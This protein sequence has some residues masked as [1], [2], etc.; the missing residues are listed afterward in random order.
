M[1]KHEDRPESA[2]PVGEAA[3]PGAPSAAAPAAPAAPAAEP[4]LDT[5]IVSRRLI[6]ASPARLFSAFADPARL[7]LWW[8]PTGFTSTF[9][10]FDFRP[11]G[12]W[13][14]LLHAPDGTDYPNANEF[15][16]IVPASR[17][18]FHHRQ[19]DHDFIMTLTFEASGPR[20]LL[21][22]HMRFSTA[23]SAARVRAFILP[24]NEQNFDRL[25]EHLATT[26]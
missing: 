20:T 18:S 11:G 8:G 23:D 7:T 16:E 19:A 13:R 24:A 9:T 15:V 1:L 25:S 12:A 22:W 2:V 21:T 17:I 10:E 5:D 3:S 26:T 14:F 4:G 6:D